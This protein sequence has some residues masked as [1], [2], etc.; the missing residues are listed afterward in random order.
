M[1]AEHKKAGE[2]LAG[3]FVLKI[4]NHSLFNRPLAQERPTPKP[5]MTMLRA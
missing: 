2:D 4:S 5:Q 1:N 3:F